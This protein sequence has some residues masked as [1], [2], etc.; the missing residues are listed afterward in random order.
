[1]PGSGTDKT[2]NWVAAAG[3]LPVNPAFASLNLA[4]AVVIDD[5]HALLAVIASCHRVLSSR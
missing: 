1:M 3:P 2:K 5:R 4:H